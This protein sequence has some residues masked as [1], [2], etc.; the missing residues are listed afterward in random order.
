MPWDAFK[1]LVMLPGHSGPLGVVGIAA[2]G[3]GDGSY[4]NVPW[5]VFKCPNRLKVQMR[6]VKLLNRL[7]PASPPFGPAESA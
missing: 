2:D 3:G 7:N 5:D 1:S 6:L 4:D